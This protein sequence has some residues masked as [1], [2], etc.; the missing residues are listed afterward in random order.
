MITSEE[1]ITTTTIKKP[2]HDWNDLNEVSKDDEG[3]NKSYYDFNYG[4]EPEDHDNDHYSKDEVN[5][6]ENIAEPEDND[7]DKNNINQPEVL[8]G[9]DKKETDVQ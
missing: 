6:D 9:Q 4:N 8:T 3:S 5:D 1:Q 2:N 7:Q